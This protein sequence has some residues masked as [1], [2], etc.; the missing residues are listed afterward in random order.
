MLTPVHLA[1]YPPAL[2]GACGASLALYEPLCREIAPLSATD[3]EYRVSGLLLLVADDAGEEA[4]GCSRPGSA[5]A[6]SPS[7][8]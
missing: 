1:E 4:A 3:P 6:G 5:S 7:S 2:A 8:A